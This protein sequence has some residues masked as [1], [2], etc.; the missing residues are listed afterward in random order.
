V[1]L[2]QGKLVIIVGDGPGF[3]T[4]RIL[5]PMLAEAVRLL[6]VKIDFCFIPQK[7]AAMC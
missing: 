7:F 1:G 4:T 6:Q 2:R 5:A 3:Y